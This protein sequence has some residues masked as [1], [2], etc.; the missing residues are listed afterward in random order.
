M[1]NHLQSEIS[2][3]L[4][5][6]VENPV[7]WYPWGPEALTRAR[8]ED[9]PIF[10][11]IGYSA[12]HWCHVMAHESF[13][14]PDIAAILNKSF[15]CIKVDREERPDLDGFYMNA[16]VAMTG[17]GGWPLS[18][19][20][21][22]DGLPF[23][24]GTYFPPAQRQR[25]PAF[26]EVLENIL[27]SWLV[28]RARINKS[29]RKLVE[30]LKEQSHWVSSALPIQKFYLD[31]AVD[32]LETTY[33]WPHGGWGAAPKFPQPM[34]IEFLLRQATRGSERALRMAVHVLEAMSRG[35]M[36]D[37]IGGGFH[38][39]STD[40]R[41]LVPHFEKMLY[42]N[43]QLALVYLHAYQVTGETAWRQ[44]C[45]STLDF[46]QRELT[47]P[48]GG[49]YCSLDADA[50]SKEGTYYTWTIGE[51]QNNLDT[52]EDFDFINT[53][54]TLNLRGNFEGRIIL[55]RA[56]I[57][58]ELAEA[59]NMPVSKVPERLQKLHASLLQIRQARLRPATDDKVLVAWNAL[60]LQ[61]FAEA[62]RYL[63]R[64]DYIATAV[65]NARFLLAS[66]HPNDRL[67]RSWRA[68]QAHINAYLDDYASLI[69]A[70]LTL[71][72]SD[73]NLLWYRAA[74][75]LCGEMLTHYK[76]TDGGFFDTR[77]D[78]ED[79]ITRPKELQ[80]NATPSG[81]ALAALAL[82]QLA[83]YNDR[84]GYLAAAHEILQK[85]QENAIQY[86]TAFSYWLSSMDFAVGPQKQVAILFE[87]ND[88]RVLPLLDVLWSAYRPR[89]VAAI[90]VFPPGS[91]ASSLFTD[92]APIRD[93]PTAYVCE[94]F[95]CRMPTT[96]PEELKRQLD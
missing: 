11:S 74:E 24:G 87:A 42:D 60:A 47:D 44:V 26:R 34:T 75:R 52:P 89:C 70:L 20:L 43:A 93:M 92:R 78:Q 27:R 68:G 19:F 62:G 90:S 67:L 54:Y 56:A 31:R 76:D 35:G 37:V 2:P 30:H 79:L 1:K 64:N 51:I 80:D 94:D 88:E 4:L 25:L 45:E 50:D 21:T 29:G 5:Q 10:L 81:N 12:C 53:A 96:S 33:D 16:V 65:R 38:R 77:A 15:I 66:L 22:A 13:E 85:V 61:A 36:Y 39:Y 95:T 58:N 3:Y 6:H 57:D 41:W 48:K 7:D 86:P 14:N 18:V 63:R 40:Y 91:G 55:Q 69:L 49:F 17:Q 23:Y 59:F 72:Q 32:A 83:A 46:I 71:Y 8:R 28:E 73:P 9:K 82:L 84:Q